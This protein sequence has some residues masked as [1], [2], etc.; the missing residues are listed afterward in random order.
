MLLACGYCGGLFELF[1]GTI[2]AGALGFILPDLKRLFGSNS[3]SGS[4]E[5][6]E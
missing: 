2:A 6:S 3:R 5:P 4:Q 1:I